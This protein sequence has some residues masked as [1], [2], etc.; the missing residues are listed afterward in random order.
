MPATGSMARS[1]VPVRSPVTAGD[2]EFLAR[3]E[4]CSLPEAEWT[5]LAH[6][7]VAWVCLNLLNPDQALARIREGILRYNTVVL[8]RRHKYHDTVT[9][10]YTMIIAGRMS[11]GEA[12]SDFAEHIDDL[13]DSE[14]PIL[15][16]YYSEELLFSDRARESFVH[17]D[18]KS[19]PA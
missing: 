19:L 16:R 14:S 1:E 2:K 5:H 7:R 3:F 15:L 8:H 17:P 13:L 12:W 6:I 9:V 11:E 10:A 18:L 4:S